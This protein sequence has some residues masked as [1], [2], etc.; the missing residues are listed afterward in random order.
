MGPA[1]RPA[2]GAVIRALNDE[3]ADV[4]KA[5]A[6]ALQRIDPDAASKAGVR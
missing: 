1:A 4:R 3:D 5:A 2:T 6:A